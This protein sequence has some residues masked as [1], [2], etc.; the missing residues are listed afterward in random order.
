VRP[1]PRL[2]SITGVSRALISTIGVDD[3]V[4]ILVAQFGWD[5]AFSALSHLEGPESG[6]ALF[7]A[8]EEL[9]FDDDLAG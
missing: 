9:V 4:R 7:R 5:L 3:A 2:K 1:S 8:V 6:P